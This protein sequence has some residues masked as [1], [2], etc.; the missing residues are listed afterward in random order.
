MLRF[1]SPYERRGRRPL[2]ER[3]AQPFM[4]LAMSFGFHLLAVWVFMFGLPLLSA[5]QG[6]QWPEVISVQILGELA[7]PASTEP[8]ADQI[9]RAPEEA[10]SP[11][12][13]QT[14]AVR[15]SP[16]SSAL[17]TVSEPQDPILP[18]PPVADP[19]MLIKADEKPQVA[20]PP[21]GT[22][23]NEEEEGVSQD[24]QIAGIMQGLQDRL[25]QQGQ[26]AA[27]PDSGQSSQGGGSTDGV[28]VHPVKAG[29]YAHVRDIIKDKWLT[30][31]GM[32]TDELLTVYRVT[33]QPDGSVSSIILERSSANAD[34][35]FSVER[36]IR[37]SSFPPLPSIFENRPT[38]VGLRFSPKDLR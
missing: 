15:P 32:I 34:F 13:D 7:G 29:Y 18:P 12:P 16:G 20:P 10:K 36:A 9:Q 38:T 33:I 6:D 27:R 14:S 35:D 8:A 25:D 5:R 22:G 30:P 11:R 17:E 19:A 28:R 24:E 2:E 3:A 37:L 26:S 1:A 21:I 31:P 23:Q 4:A